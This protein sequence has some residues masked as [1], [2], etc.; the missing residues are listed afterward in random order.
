ELR[1]QVI[2][3]I[4][5]LNDHNI[6]KWI[7]YLAALEEEDRIN[8][9]RIQKELKAQEGVEVEIE[10]IR[11]V[12]IKLSRG[13]LIDYKEFGGWFTHINDP[14]LQ[15][16]LKIWGKIEVAGIKRTDI[17]NKVNFKRQSKNSPKYY[18]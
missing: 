16:F 5:R 3:W 9:E 6:T 7:L 1:D 8:P 2:K 11:E 14:I 17:E 12:M 4:E 13:D 15:E 18:S 10:K